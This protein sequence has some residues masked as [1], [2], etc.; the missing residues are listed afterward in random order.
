VAKRKKAGKKASAK[1]APVAQQA[2]SAK[3]APVKKIKVEALA[4][5]Y[6]GEKYRRT[7]DVFEI[8]SPRHLGKWMKE[9]DPKRPEKI[10]S[11]GEALDRARQDT[12]ADRAA[13]RGLSAPI[14]NPTG[15]SE[16]I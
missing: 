12:L 15:A 3:A 5:G 16:V 6:Y 7:G 9:T 10:T 14:D 13:T 2:A 1:A 11:S 8:D 4:D